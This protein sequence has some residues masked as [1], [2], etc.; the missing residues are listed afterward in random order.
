[1]H[2]LLDILNKTDA[3]S[4]T[5]VFES[6]ERANPVIE[7]RFSAININENGKAFP[8]EWCFMPKSAREPALEVADFVMH[9][10]HGLAWDQLRGRDGYQRRDFRSV[11]HRKNPNLSSFMLME[12]VMPF[13]DTLE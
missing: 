8:V 6:S 4:L 13:A 3:P 11:F 9:A 12:S 7:R 2:R 5:V 1:V 10:V